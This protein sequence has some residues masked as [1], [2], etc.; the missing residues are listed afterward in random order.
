MPLKK[1]TI[2]KFG[3][4]YLLGVN[5]D[6]KHVYLEEPSWDCGWSWGFGYLH[7]YTNDK[8]P[9]LSRDIS[10]HTHFD[11]MFLGG[12]KCAY[13]EFKDYFEDTVLTDSEIWQLV[14]LMQTCYT[15]KDAA[16]LHHYGYSHYTDSAK[17]EEIEDA[18]LEK[19]INEV[20]LPAAL[21]KIERLLTE[22]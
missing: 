13:D 20:M 14:D 21:K 4:H 2:N 9:E 6:G 17:T 11:S 1:K 18:E 10:F 3:K 7:G 22:E 15:L 8:A 16:R 5:K 12:R 19:R